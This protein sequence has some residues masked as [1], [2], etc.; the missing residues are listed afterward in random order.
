MA[1][2][3]HA[4][5]DYEFAHRLM[6]LVL[7]PHLR[8]GH[9]IER[10]ITIQRGRPQVRPDALAR[11]QHIG[12]VRDRRQHGHSMCL[13]PTPARDEPASHG[14]T[15][16]A[17]QADH[18]ISG[19][20]EQSPAPGSLRRTLPPIWRAFGALR[21]GPSFAD[22]TSWSC[23][24]CCHCGLAAVPCLLRIGPHTLAVYGSVGLDRGSPSWP[25]KWSAL[26]DGPPGPLDDQETS[27]F[28]S[29]P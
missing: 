27:H 25:E 29:F 8:P 24:R 1:H 16:P 15:V 12:Q 5:A 7:D 18:A 26:A 20:H 9:R 11:G 10:R 22:I 6:V 14:R 4:T 2:K 23:R 21:T 13:P 17:L 19:L 28:R 3:V